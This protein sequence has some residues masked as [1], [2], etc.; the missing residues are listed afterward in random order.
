MGESVKNQTIAAGVT[1]LMSQLLLELQQAAGTTQVLSGER[2][3]RYYRRGYRSGEGHADA[4]VLPTS[5]KAYWRVLQVCV[6]HQAVIIM[7]AANTGL[8]EGSTPSGND[9]Q[10]PVV[11]INTNKLGGLHLSPDKQTVIALAGSS[12]HQLEKALAPYDREPHS[13]IGSSCLGASVIGGIANNSG[14]A[15]IQR[16][17]A[18]T[19]YALYAQIDADG[20][21]KLVNHLGIPLAGDP[22]AQLGALQQGKLDWQALVHEPDKMASDREYCQR[23]RD[24]ES[25][26]PARFNADPRRLYEASG[27]AGKL[28]VFA[29]RLD[30]FAKPAKQQAFYLGCNDPAVFTRLRQAVLTQFN[31]LPVYGEY[32]HRDAFNL[33]RRYGKDTFVAIERLGTDSMPA[34]FAQK[35]KFTGWFNQL[36]L[37]NL[38][39]KLMQWGSCVLPEHLPARLLSMASEFE[40]HLIIKMADEGIS[41][42][43]AFA[44][45]FFAREAGKC[46]TL[47]ANETSKALLHRFAVAGAAIRYQQMHSHE[48]ED[49]LALDIALPR[50]CHH[51]FEQL[52]PQLTDKL[53]QPLYYGHFFCHVFHQ[54][55]L[56]KKGE[57]VEAIKQALLALLEERGARYPAEHNFGHLYPASEEVK[58]FY[59]T[60]DPTNSFNPG[61][62]KATRQ[63]H[64]GKCC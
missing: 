35:G 58:A 54:D 44:T 23:L 39:D 12:L 49:V 29:V 3:T 11:I 1:D 59:Q 63:R 56:V 8:T 51:W 26:T 41:E 37:T 53:I 45:D 21:L 25:D 16:G 40:H 19:H 57:D 43:A 30:T 9:Y 33:A 27:C 48:C 28:A 5:L 14:G 24:T 55:Y 22:D 38:P 62:G 10:R 4:V 6:A 36:G 20:E 31:T 13:V 18:F 61:I 7:Q 46:L 64:W 52:P 17:P 42:F 2:R 15:L 60:L 34:L 50:N 47:N 32:I